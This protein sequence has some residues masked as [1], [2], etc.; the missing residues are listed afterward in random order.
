MNE[1]DSATPPPTGAQD[2]PAD[3]ADALR[4]ARAA[5]RPKR[6]RLGLRK[7]LRNWNAA[8]RFAERLQ[9]LERAG[10]PLGD[11][12]ESA[13]VRQVRVF[14]QAKRAMH[15]RIWRLRGAL[16]RTRVQLFFQRYWRVILTILLLGALGYALWL[17][18]TWISALVVDLMTPALP[19]PQ[20]SPPTTG[21]TP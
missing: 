3:L 1:T 7:R 13:W 6:Q 8:Q 2:L 21:E 5:A 17:S 12:F 19:D 11:R 9:R 16:L 10:H 15:R 20:A 14:A 18:W 4:A